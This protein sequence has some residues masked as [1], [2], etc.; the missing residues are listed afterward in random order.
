MDDLGKEGASLPNVPEGGK[1][2]ERTSEVL[3]RHRNEIR[4]IAYLKSMLLSEYKQLPYYDFSEATE[5]EQRN[6]MREL[7]DA[8]TADGKQL[9]LEVGP[10]NRMSPLET[11]VHARERVVFAVDH[12]V[13]PKD[14]SVR[15]DLA[16]AAQEKGSLA[17]FFGLDGTT[18]DEKL[19]FERV[20]MVFPNPDDQDELAKSVSR[21][22]KPGGDLLILVDPL[23]HGEPEA[24]DIISTLPE[25]FDADVRNLGRSRVQE[26]YGISD[27]VLGEKFT[28]D[29]RIPVIVAHRR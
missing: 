5:T 10:G 1:W 9:F 3:E 21:Y 17:V 13:Q 8:A 19:Q 18:L 15:K 29:V 6:I 2:A 27:S 23:L 26:R 12:A 11:A 25:D 22:V 7:Y 28:E 4:P 16:S 20:Q 24:K 14:R